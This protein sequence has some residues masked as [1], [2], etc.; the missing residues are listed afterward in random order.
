MTEI[1]LTR[2]SSI[3]DITAW[4]YSRI[5]NNEDHPTAKQDLLNTLNPVNIK[6]RGGVEFVAYMG[7]D[8]MYRGR[9]LNTSA[10]MLL[11]A[12]RM[13]SV[14]LVNLQNKL[15]IPIR[16]ES[17]AYPRDGK[18]LGSPVGERWMDKGPRAYRSLRGREGD[19]WS[20]DTGLY[21]AEKRRQAFLGIPYM[22]WVR[23]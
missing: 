14:L 12:P 19:V 16:Y 10:D 2:K 22:V 9:V 8:W 13:A 20:D 18:P 23:Q 17:V 5:V 3:Q 1:R 7:W 21:K 15:G 11:A 6:P 4:I